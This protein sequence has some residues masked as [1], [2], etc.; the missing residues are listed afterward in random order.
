MNPPLIVSDGPEEMRPETTSIG[1]NRQ[2]VQCVKSASQFLSAAT[3]EDPR[4][5]PQG[6]ANSITKSIR[7]RDGL[8][9]A[10]PAQIALLKNYLIRLSVEFK[11]HMQSTSTC[12]GHGPPYDV[13][14][15]VSA[16]SATGCLFFVASPW[17]SSV[18]TVATLFA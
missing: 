12:P 3:P 15:L 16:T 5:Q 13:V 2:S 8:L 7:G 6:N 9:P 1:G 14:R 4:K 11:D 18:V 10:A 17:S